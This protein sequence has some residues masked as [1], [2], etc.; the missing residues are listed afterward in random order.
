METSGKYRK[1]VVCPTGHV[2]SDSLLPPRKEK[3]VPERPE[4]KSLPT[5]TT[6]LAILDRGLGTPTGRHR[7]RQEICRY[8]FKSLS[9]KI[10]GHTAQN[11]VP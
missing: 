10:Q 2:D 11:F 9:K 8:L 4:R 6:A 1:R 7:G 3:S 5:A